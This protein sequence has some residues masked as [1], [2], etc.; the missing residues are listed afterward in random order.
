[1]AEQYYLG[2]KEI[3]KT[4]AKSAMESLF[5]WQ[6]K[7][8]GRNADSN[9]EETAKIINE[10]TSFSAT[11]KTN[12]TLEEIKSE[13]D[14]GYPVISLHYGFGL[15]NPAIP[16]LANGSSYHMMVL[17]GYDNKK[18]E[19]ITNDPGNEKKGLDFRYKYDTILNTLG[20]FNHETK[21][22]D[23]LPTVLF[24]KPK[25]LVK[26]AG[27]KRIYLI[28]NDEKRYIS[29][30]NVFKNHRWSWSLVKP[31]AKGDLEKIPNGT[32]INK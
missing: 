13:L 2:K 24:T 22:V 14:N 29:H 28:E 27:G 26:V 12:P 4:L 25:N 31:M 9:A 16:F 10:Y 18:K 15:N 32:S 3:S 19:F 21:K 8:F 30:P 6:N 7:N 20:D 11:V 1:M 23:G 5:N 17:V